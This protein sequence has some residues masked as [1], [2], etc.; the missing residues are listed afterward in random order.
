MPPTTSHKALAGST[1]RGCTVHRRLGSVSPGHTRRGGVLLSPSRLAHLRSD[2]SDF[3]TAYKALGGSPSV[4]AVVS[5]V[6][7]R[8]P[9]LIFSTR[10]KHYVALVPEEGAQVALYAE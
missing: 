2:M 9:A 5:A 8:E 4:L 1:P 6:L 7:E 3:A 10:A